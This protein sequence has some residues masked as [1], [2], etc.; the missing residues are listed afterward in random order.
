VEKSRVEA[1]PE[2]PFNVGERLVFSV[3][4]GFVTAGEATMS[5]VRIDTLFGS[6]SYLLQS[7][8][9]TNEIFS[10]F[11]KVNDRVESHLDIT[12]FFSRHFMKKLREGSYKKD[13]EIFFDHEG[14]YARYAE[15]DSLSIL[16]GTQDVLSA[17][18]FLRTQDLNV[19]KT[20]S[21]PC[22]DNKKNYPLEIRVLRKEKVMVPAGKFECYVLEP[23]LKTGGL[24]KKEAKMLIWVTADDKKMPVLMETKMKIGSIAAKLKDYRLSI[25]VE[26][27]TGGN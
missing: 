7:L 26:P 12:G 19:G 22:H 4:Y 11:Y 14:E 3:E 24:M 18:F 27:S 17:F 16:P 8:A 6:P 1:V 21:F 5:V 20:M 2:A 25:E 13:L 15:G 23:R 10:A 9:Q